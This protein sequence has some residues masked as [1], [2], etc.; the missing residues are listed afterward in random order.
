MWRIV[1]AGAHLAVG[2]E[3]YATVSVPV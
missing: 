3:P 2:I 1:G